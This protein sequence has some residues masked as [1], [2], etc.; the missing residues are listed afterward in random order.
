MTF[1]LPSRFI[2]QSRR[3]PSLWG[4]FF[5]EDFLPSELFEGGYEG[6]K[7]YEEN[8]R[9]N[10]EVPVPGLNPND[11]EVELRKGILWI[12]GES[13]E[14]EQARE[15]ERKYYRQATRSYNFSIALPS[16]VEEKQEP[17]ADYADG[18]LK[19]S[20]QLSKQD[21]RKKI[22]VKVNQGSKRNQTSNNKQ[23]GNKQ[24]K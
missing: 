9:L 2:K 5:N 13:K 7:I 17:Q 20:F 21:E 19:I 1:N 8:N 4:N 18:I 11:I 14:E 23:T 12:K 10:V 3:F 6:V 24:S 15:G 22:P 16:Q